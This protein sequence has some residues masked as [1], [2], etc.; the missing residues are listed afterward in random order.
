MNAET[1]M[2]MANVFATIMQLICNFR[3]ERGAEETADDQ[4]FMEWL[5]KHQ[6][7]DIKKLIQNN[8]A[9]QTGVAKLLRADHTVIMEKLDGINTVLASLASQVAEFRELTMALV[10]SAEL[11][12]QGISIL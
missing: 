12:E 7:E 9:L 4:Q 1:A 5:Q 6:H 11:S 10:P 8:A 2:T 3:A